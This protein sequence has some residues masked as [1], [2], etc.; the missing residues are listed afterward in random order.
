M[1]T[2]LIFMHPKWTVES[3][4]SDWHHNRRGAAIFND[5]RSPM[6]EQYFGL[7]RIANPT[8]IIYLRYD[9][10]AYHRSFSFGAVV[11][12]PLFM[13]LI[14]ILLVIEKRQRH[15]KEVCHINRFQLKSAP[16]L[17]RL[18]LFFGHSFLLTICKR[19]IY[20]SSLVQYL[21]HRS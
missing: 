18:F 7:L 6:A 9:W 13:W 11:S 14:T 12:L 15:M 1:S 20:G 8:I 17:M 3:P 2:Q 5:H 4:I 10:L 19:Q 21:P 16:S